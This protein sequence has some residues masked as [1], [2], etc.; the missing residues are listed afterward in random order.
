MSRKRQMELLETL[1]YSL[2]Q[3]GPAELDGV[4][5]YYVEILAGDE[6]AMTVYM[7]D[8]HAFSPRPKFSKYDWLKPSQIEWF[9]QTASTRRNSRSADSKHMDISF[10]HI[11]LPE[12]DSSESPRL[13][14]W[15]EGV[16]AANFNTG[17][18]DVLL[19]QGIVM[20][21]AGQY[22]YLLWLTMLTSSDHCNDYC[23]LSSPD[24][25]QSKS[26]LWMCYAGGVGFGGYGC[27]DFVRRVRV[28]DID[29]KAARITTWK[30][31]EH[32]EDAANVRLD[33]QVIVEGGKPKKLALP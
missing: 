33:E 8:T 26:S 24:A 30:R 21:S 3:A 29:T 22:V 16:G 14:K 28:F 20:V 17:F 15:R 2:S 9:R 7:L 12:Y 11:P 18:R 19:E 10:I 31:L 6:P 1:P 13:G 25:P 27:D 23:L 32:G 4:G 5:N